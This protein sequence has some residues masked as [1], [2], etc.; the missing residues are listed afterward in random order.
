M[1]TAS[2]NSPVYAIFGAYGGIGRTLAARLAREGSNLALVG[3]NEEKVKTLASE[4]NALALCADI[5]QPNRAQECLDQVFAKWGRVDGVVN[6]CGSILL[7]PAHLTNL[8]EFEQT[9]K[10]NLYTAFYTVQA[11]AKTM[12]KT[13]GAIVLV[14]TGAARIGVPNHEAIAAAKAGVEGL[15]LSAAATYAN[16]GIRVNCVAPGLTRTPLSERITSNDSS[17]KASLAMHPLGRIGEPE[18]IASAISWMLSSE[19]SWMTGQTIAID[20]GLSSI[21]SR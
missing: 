17:L 3:R 11:A 8:E 1:N 4:L 6:L 5:A 18:D 16:R 15:T 19:Q 20:G 10:T 21:R 9:L 14:S 13:G 7:K 2:Q 12:M